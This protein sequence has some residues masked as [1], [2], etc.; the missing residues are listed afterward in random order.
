MFFLL[1]VQCLLVCLFVCLFVNCLL[2]C[3]FVCVCF[4]FLLFAFVFSLFGCSFLCSLVRWVAVLCL[5]VTLLLDCLSAF[6]SLC[7]VAIAFFVDGGV[8]FELSC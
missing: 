6:R 3:L 4:L 1:F 5:R 2:V 7:F 8:V